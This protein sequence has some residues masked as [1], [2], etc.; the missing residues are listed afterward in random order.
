[1]LEA[2][3]IGKELTMRDA[4]AEMVDLVVSKEDEVVGEHL[5]R[6]GQISGGERF[7]VSQTCYDAIGV[8]RG[9]SWR[10]CGDGGVGG[11]RL[12][13]SMEKGGKRENGK[14]G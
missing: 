1:M 8:G 12:V 2:E 4:A 5:W 11:L 13:C 14:E 3:A 10:R 7:L 9:S 6:K